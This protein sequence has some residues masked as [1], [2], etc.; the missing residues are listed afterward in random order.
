MSL[1]VASFT[2]FGSITAISKAGASQS[3]EFEDDQNLF[4]VIT[5]AGVMAAEGTCSGNLACGKCKVKV[6]GSVPE[7]EDEEK[8]LLDGAAAGTR[9]ACAIV[10]NG[11][12]NGATVQ[13]L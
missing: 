9:L 11:D 12:C 3:L 2:R 13:V 5:G 1:S 6:T 10:L 4:E 7:A 8:E